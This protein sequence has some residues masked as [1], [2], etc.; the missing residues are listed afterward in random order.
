M[1]LVFDG[2]SRLGSAVCAQLLSEGR[3]VRVFTRTPEEGAALSLLGADVVSGDRLDP[4]T[5][6]LAFRDVDQVVSCDPVSLHKRRRQITGERCGHL[7]L[8]RV[9]SEARV[10]HLVLVSAMGACA[11]HPHEGWRL[12]H[13]SETRLRASGLSHTIVRPTVSMESWAG[14]VGAAI[15][16]GRRVT[17]PG[18][19]TNPVNCI[20]LEDVSNYVL[21]ALYHPGA[22][23]RTIEIGGPQNLTLLDVVETFERVSGRKARKRHLPLALLE[24]AGRLLRPLSGAASLRS[25][26]TV[27][28]SSGERRFDPAPTLAE[29]PLRLTTLE[30]FAQR[31]Y[32]AMT[33]G[34]GGE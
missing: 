20:A 11:D 33:R 23:G 5:V 17:I 29:F 6:R 27:Y 1:V 28:L 10:A 3:D 34:Q 7:D 9:A 24:T 22:R 30:Q 25:A 12:R 16:E 32:Q 26:A 18:P 13:E 14:P 21:L 2:T 15:I 31:T 19:G 4:V 8:I